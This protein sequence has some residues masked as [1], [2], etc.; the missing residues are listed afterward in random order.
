M[1]LSCFT[2]EENVVAA[3]ASLGN[4]DLNQGQ[5]IDQ[6]TDTSSRWKVADRGLNTEI[7][8]KR[9]VFRNWDE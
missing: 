9:L 2:P 5:Q 3:V 6:A 4:D 1:Q 8:E 7:L